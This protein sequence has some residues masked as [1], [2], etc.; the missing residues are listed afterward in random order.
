MLSTLKTYANKDTNVSFL[1]SFAQDGKGA[2][3]SLFKGSQ[4]VT[5]ELAPADVKALN[6]A[7]STAYYANPD[8]F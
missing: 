3:F 2:T 1:L 8:H 5:V 6:E 7:I 4:G